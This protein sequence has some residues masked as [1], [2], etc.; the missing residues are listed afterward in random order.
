M[1]E[2]K[3][4]VLKS[5]RAFQNPFFTGKVVTENGSCRAGF[6][7]KQSRFGKRARPLSHR[8]AMPALP[9]GEP[10]AWRQSFRLKPQSV[11]FRQSLSLW[12]RC[13]GVSRDGEGEDANK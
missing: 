5:L 13:H 12:E 10:L 11:R 3:K 6:L 2:T 9:K 1:I 7:R 4:G 8:F